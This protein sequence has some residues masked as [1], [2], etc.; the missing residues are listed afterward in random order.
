MAKKPRFYLRRKDEDPTSILLVYRYRNNRIV[1]STGASVSP[2][3][4][5][6]RDQR[7]KESQ[8]PAYHRQI[9]NLINRMEATTLELIY[10]LKA[11]GRLPEPQVFK[12]ALLQ[13]LGRGQEPEQADL[14]TFIAEFIRE[15]EAMNRPKGS[16]QVYRTCQKHLEE[17]AQARRRKIDFPDI[18]EAFKNDFLAYLYAQNFTDTHVNKIFGTLKTFLRDAWKRGASKSDNF[19]KVT[20]S[21]PKREVDN[22]S[23]TEKELETL[24][25]LD[26][27]GNERLD[28]VRDLF[29]IGCFTGLRFS[30]YSTIKPENIVTIEG[31]ECI[32]KT[33]QKTKKKVFIP[34]T[35]PTLRAILEK[36]EMK[37][38]RK[39][40]NQKLNKYLKELAQLAGFDQP[41]EINEYRAGR[42]ETKLYKKWELVST[43]TARR[44]FASN[45]IRSGIPEEQV[46]KFTGHTTVSS[47]RKYIKIEGEE[48]AVNLAGHRFFTGTTDDK[49]PGA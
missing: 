25:A 10:E 8:G 14:F 12:D 20:L 38:P 27:S 16:I 1:I 32:A 26:F 35:N 6:D 49:A 24:A 36:H 21:I 18:T 40:S 4:W 30:D 46:M 29:L 13:R 42:H 5:N 2:K 19:A 9:N 45:A 47:F 11:K 15:R 28:R 3:F 34:L 22:I 23:L 37:A 43:H 31:V 44:S 39:I 33:T 7:V 41:V 17:Y 48:T